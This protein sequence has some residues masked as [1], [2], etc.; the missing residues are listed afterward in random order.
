MIHCV[1]FS[2][3]I[4]HVYFFAFDSYVLSGGDL[5]L[6]DYNGRTALHQA[7]A[8]GHI[9]IVKHL[10]NQFKVP[11]NVRDRYTIHTMFLWFQIISGS[12]RVTLEV[13]FGFLPQI[14]GTF[15]HTLI[16]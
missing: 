5:T 14:V 15:A 2:L 11:Q 1:P 12:F 3:L 8:E 6:G 9:E 7:C 13:A 16:N 10:V 4:F